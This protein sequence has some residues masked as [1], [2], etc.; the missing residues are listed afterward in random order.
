M[1]FVEN[2]CQYSESCLD[3]SG[4]YISTA[5]ND[6]QVDDCLYHQHPSSN[7]EKIFLFSKENTGCPCPTKGVPKVK[8]YNVR[9]EV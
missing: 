8:L 9:S 5:V 3:L 1:M 2:D 6:A 7:Y 4:E